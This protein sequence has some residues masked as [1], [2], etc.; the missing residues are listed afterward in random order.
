MIDLDCLDKRIIFIFPFQQNSTK[1]TIFK[2]TS[3]LQKIWQCEAEKRITRKYCGIVISWHR[4]K[5]FRMI[6]DV[7]RNSTCKYGNQLI[8]FYLAHI[9]LLCNFNTLKYFSMTSRF[10]YLTDLAVVHDL[11]AGHLAVVVLVLVHADVVLRS[12]TLYYQLTIIYIFA[13]ILNSTV[14]QLHPLKL[15]LFSDTINKAT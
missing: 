6:A 5:C 2:S 11:L 3:T 12:E 14:C 10:R 7:C 4:L 9:S 8:L 15:E 13:I 1:V